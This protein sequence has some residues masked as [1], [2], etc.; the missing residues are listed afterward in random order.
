VN[1]ET[2][3]NERGSAMS[4]KRA[5]LMPAAVAVI[6]LTGAIAAAHAG[7]SIVVG[8]AVPFAWPFTPINIAV[9]EGIMKKHGFDDV[10]VV[11]F[12][13]DAKEQQALLAGSIEFGLGSGPG[14]A[15]D[16]KGGAGIGVCAFYGSPY[17]LGISMPY[18]SPVTNVEELKGKKL[19]VTTVGSLTAWLAQH[20]S[21]QLGW[22]ADGITPVALGGLPAQLAA[23][24]THQVDG[25]VVAPEAAFPLEAKKEIHQIY[26]FGD[27]LPHFITEAI[28]ARKDL[29]KNNPDMVRR[30][31]AAWI[32]TLDF[33][34]THKAETVEISAKVLNKSPSIMSRVYDYEKR[35]FIWDCSFDPQA[36]GLLD[37]T[38][39]EMHLLNSKPAN[40]ELF[41]AAFLPKK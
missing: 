33:I 32:E 35:G 31:V 17:S 39:V 37:E 19:A 29:T 30:F 36:I 10:K 25:L 26:N 13:G 8:E 22:G 38:F 21:Q 40:N 1:D 6:T 24:R 18:D 27:L 5:F 11:G 34:R 41:T 14:L 23:L 7:D 3:T 4:V 2:A 9:Q 16:A 12:A 15:F 28:F 20:L